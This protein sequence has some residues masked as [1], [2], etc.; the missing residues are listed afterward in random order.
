MSLSA[1]E[2]ALYKSRFRL[3]QLAALAEQVRINFPGSS[4]DERN[5]ILD[6]IDRVR[7][8]EE[9]LISLCNGGDVN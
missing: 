6:I 3:L 9:C 4:E 1:K 8:R 2:T 7:V 5:A